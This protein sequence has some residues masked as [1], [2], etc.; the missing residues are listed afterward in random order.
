[1]YI[2][3]YI[4]IAFIKDIYNESPFCV[5]VY[6][7]NLESPLKNSLK[8]ARWSFYISHPCLIIDQ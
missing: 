5:Y 4:I 7:S 2:Y 6:I 3:I 8:H 1:M